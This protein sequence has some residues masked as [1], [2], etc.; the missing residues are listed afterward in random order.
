MVNM[1][2]LSGHRSKHEL[3]KNWNWKTIGTYLF[4]SFRQ[5]GV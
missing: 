2:R 4:Y 3:L 1:L 5:E